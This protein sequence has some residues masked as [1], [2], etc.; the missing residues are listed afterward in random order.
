MRTKSAFFGSRAEP[1]ASTPRRLSGL[2]ALCAGLSLQQPTARALPPEYLSS[3][4]FH[5]TD[6]KV[7]A[8]RWESALGGLLITRD[9]GK[10]FRALPAAAF[11]KYGMVGRVPFRLASDGAALI[12]LGDGFF[13][14]DASGCNVAQKHEAQLGAPWV[15]EIVPHPSDVDIT[16]FVTTGDTKGKHAGLWKRDKTGTLTALGLSEP[17]EV[18]KAGV[19]VQ[20]LAVIAQASAMDG[21]RFIETGTRQTP[22]NGQQSPTTSAV[23]RYSDDLGASWTERSVPDPDQTQGVV[24]LLAVEPG[25]PMKL[26]VSLEVTAGATDQPDP[27]YVSVDG[28]TSFKLY[29]KELLTTG[30]ALRLANGQLLLGDSGSP[31]GLWLADGIGMPLRKIRDDSVKCLAQQPVAASEPKQ[32]GKIFMCKAY[33]IGILDVA[34]AEFCGIF[35]INETAGFVSC[36]SADLTTNAA[37]QSQLCGAWCGPAHYASTPMCA[38]YDKPN[39]ICG[40]QARAYDTKDPD[41]SKHWIEPPGDFGAARCAGFERSVPAP[42]DAGVGSDDAGAGQADAS[43]GSSSDAGAGPKSDAGVATRSDAGSKT[44][45]GDGGGCSCSVPQRSSPFSSLAWTALAG[46]ALL[47]LRRRKR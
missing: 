45:N 16:F 22:V 41:P 7:L 44:E 43:N 32:S 40:I 23:L 34:K 28:G 19:V 12:G 4:S 37:V 14:D 17:L 35:Q 1:R 18:G 29:T 21:L 24:R 10:T 39:V 36:P 46:F 47:V 2:L 33:E 8:V 6:P 25:E 15:A 27:V 26:V 38:A 11:Y 5:P 13:E 30:Q 9:G 3:A 20:G 42:G 31:G